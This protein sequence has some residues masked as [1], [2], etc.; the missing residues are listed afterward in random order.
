MSGSRCFAV[1]TDVIDVLRE[2]D[3]RSH[4]RFC[5]Y[6]SAYLDRSLAFLP[7][8]SYNL[9]DTEP[10]GRDVAR[11]SH[12]TSKKPL[13]ILC[14]VTS[15]DS[16]YLYVHGRYHVATMHCSRVCQVVCSNDIAHVSVMQSPSILSV[17]YV[18]A[19]VKHRYSLQ[20]VSALFS[21]IQGHVNTIS[22]GVPSILSSWRNSLRQ[23]DVKI[24]A[25]QGIL[26][27]YG[28]ESKP[29]SVLLDH[30]ILGKTSDYAN[31]LEQFFA[32][33][34]MNDQLLL[35]MEKTLHNGL[36]GVEASA[37]AN[38][39]APAR[40]LAF[41][42]NEL[43][44][45]DDELLPQFEDMCLCTRTLLFSIEFLLTQIVDARFRLRDFCAWLRSTAAEIKAKDT[46]PN[47]VQHENA[48]KRRVSEQLL[49]RVA[50]CFQDDLNW[51]NDQ[52]PT[53]DVICCC[54]SVRIYIAW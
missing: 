53:E 34:Q 13:S 48:R 54:V 6:R 52:G 25:L 51:T 27:S 10:E 7:P 33:V 47:S 21:S 26:R 29:S 42:A 28:V 44:G 45:L 12:P 5:R 1:F 19:L 30:I 8:S 22:E 40:S 23:L 14:A 36:A 46:P 20:I 37:R 32:G 35:R 2:N 31:A 16:I 15:D 3:H 9:N 39:L 49:R 43:C 11:K 24:D 41:D 18:P 50:D 4:Q 17:Y 38:L